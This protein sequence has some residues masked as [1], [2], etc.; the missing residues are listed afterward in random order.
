MNSFK[1]INSFIRHFT[2]KDMDFNQFNKK[3]RKP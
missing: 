2:Y 3:N 1:N